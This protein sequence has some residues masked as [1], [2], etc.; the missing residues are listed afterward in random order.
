[1]TSKRH[2][3]LAYILPKKGKTHL[4]FLSVLCSLLLFPS[5]NQDEDVY[6]YMIGLPPISTAFPDEKTAMV[7]STAEEQD[8]EYYYKID[9]YSAAAGFNEQIALNPQT[10]VIY[11]GALI[12]GESILDG[13]YV[14][15]PAKR[16]PIT[17]STSLTGADH[18]SAVIEDPK[19]SSVREAINELMDQEYDVPPANLG[20]TQEQAYSASQLKLSLRSS[21]DAGCVDVSGGFDYSNKKIQTRLIAK[22]IQVYYTLDMDTPLSPADLFAEDPD[23][24]VLGTYMPMYVS[25]V[26][27]GRMAL[28]TVESELE[29]SQVRAFLDVD[30]SG[31]NS[32]TKE[33]FESLH[34][35]S[36]MKVYILGGS[37]QEAGKTVNGYD[38]YLNYITSG[39]SF[40]KESPGAPIA[41]KLRYIKDNTIGK[42]VFAASY[43]IRTAIPRTDN[44]LIDTDVILHQIK[45]KFDDE[46]GT[47]VEIRGTIQSWRVRDRT[48]TIHNHFDGI[49]MG[50]FATHIFNENSTTKRRLTDCIFQDTIAVYID[51]YEEDDS[52]GDDQ[53]EEQLFFIPV[54]DLF[55]QLPEEFISPEMEVREKGGSDWIKIKFKCVSTFRRIPD[56]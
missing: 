42:I 44:L 11:P 8:E 14:P 18:V 1:M 53:F 26:T 48:E 36:T 46:P 27:Y 47:E 29:E 40:S 54:T 43:P 15:I 16:K 23:E 50:L 49:D 45:T 5:C 9:Y 56:E 22:Y 21:Y 4:L 33:D 28:F 38:E 3:P 55:F 12:K 31:G 7:D 32:M 35:K 10:D 34:A 30:Y 2:F 20:F 41:Y 17:I 51:L 13:S 52:S 24:A 39:A 37:G 25:T 19:L 6:E